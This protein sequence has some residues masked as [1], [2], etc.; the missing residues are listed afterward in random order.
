MC[1]VGPQVHNVLHHALFAQALNGRLSNGPHSPIETQNRC[2]PE[3]MTGKRKNRSLRRVARLKATYPQ[4]GLR[5][6]ALRAGE[7]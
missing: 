2:R 6:D 7:E 5:G 4:E 3:N 1:G